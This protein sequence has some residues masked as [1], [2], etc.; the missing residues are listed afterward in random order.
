MGPEL[1]GS[2]MSEDELVPGW[3]VPSLCLMDQLFIRVWHP[4]L[5]ST[6]G[7]AALGQRGVGAHWYNDRVSAYGSPDSLIQGIVV[8]PICLSYG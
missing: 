5:L 8:G 3:Y 7:R 4:F 2:Q 6:Q 1:H